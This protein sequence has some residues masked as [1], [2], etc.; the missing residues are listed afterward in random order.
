[1]ENILCGVS[2]LLWHPTNFFFFINTSASLT[3]NYTWNITQRAGNIDNPG[4]RAPG[5][6][7]SAASLLTGT[8]R[9]NMVTETRLLFGKEDG[10]N[11][12]KTTGSIAGQRHERLGVQQQ[13]DEEEAAHSA[14]S[15]RNREFSLLVKLTM[16]QCCPSWPSS[17]TAYIFNSTKAKSGFLS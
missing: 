1:M 10:G 14:S 13:K 12:R 2:C 16:D 17:S 4:K 8:A 7:M 5:R 11:D 9:T 3:R 15:T 6:Y